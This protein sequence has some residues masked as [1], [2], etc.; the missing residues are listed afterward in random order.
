[1][2]GLCAAGAGYRGWSLAVV[3]LQVGRVGRVLSVWAVSVWRMGMAMGGRG[4]CRRGVVL[5]VCR[6]VVVVVVVVWRWVLLNVAVLSVVWWMCV[7]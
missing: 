2:F 6:W 4:G 7:A 3:V 1:M 5:D